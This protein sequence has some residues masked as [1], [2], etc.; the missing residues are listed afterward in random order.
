MAAWGGPCPYAHS[1]GIV[2][3]QLH[4]A[5]PELG[6]GGVPS[7]S[8]CRFRFKAEERQ[9]HP[10]DAVQPSAK[11]PQSCAPEP[12]A[13]VWLQRGRDG[14]GSRGTV[15]QGRVPLS[16]AVSPRAPQTSASPSHGQIPRTVSV[17]NAGV[18]QGCLQAVS[19]SS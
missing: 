17:G 8:H 9:I 11:V 7:G 15:P 4:L 13:S 2:A 6:M 3:C 16:A 18:K 12:C 1:W 14:A 10:H 19:L 5:T